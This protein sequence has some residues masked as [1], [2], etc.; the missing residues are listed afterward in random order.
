MSG[1]TFRT[2]LLFLYG[3][4][5]R[6]EEAL[7]LEYRHVDLAQAVIT[8]EQTKFYKSRLV[9][10]GADVHRI[11]TQHLVQRKGKV[12]SCQSVFRANGPSRS[13]FKLWTRVSTGS[14]SMLESHAMTSQRTSPES[15]T[16][17]IP[18]RF[19]GWLLGINRAKT[20]TASSDACHGRS[21]GSPGSADHT[22]TPRSC[23][24]AV[25]LQLRCPS[26]GGCQRH[27]RRLD[28]A[29]DARRPVL[30]PAAR[31]GA[32]DSVVSLVGPMATELQALV[33]GRTSADRVFVNRSGQPLTRFG[34]HEIVTRHA[35]SL[36]E[37]F[38]EL[39]KKRPTPHTIRHTCATHLLRAG[40]DINT[41]LG[42]VSLNTT[43]IYAEVDLEM[44]AQALAKCSVSPSKTKET[45]AR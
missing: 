32:E 25:S 36:K 7:R 28:A 45:A 13:T 12:A 44:K 39:H 3:T 21:A 22:G 27:R 26:G 4:G 40:V 30:C 41:W 15:T 11:L 24:A 6:L 9:P 37:Q 8:V 10:V 19:T 23:P 38:P 35:Q 34:V 16:C 43:N 29:R 17:D 14:R 31:Q 42:H 18:L 1:K 2:L 5:L 20:L 33:S